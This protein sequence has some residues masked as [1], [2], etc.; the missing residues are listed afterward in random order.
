LKFT[1]DVLPVHP[2]PR[3]LESFTGYLTRLAD[4]NGI[5]HLNNLSV[6]SGF[7]F[8]EVRSPSDFPVLKAFYRLPDIA[9][10]SVEDLNGTTFY[11]LLRKFGRT[12]QSP[13]MSKHFLRESIGTHL[14]YCPMCLQ[15]HG[16]ISLLW[17]F[18]S[19]EVC[20]QHGTYLLDH[21]LHCDSVI[22][23]LANGL[24]VGVCPV[25]QHDLRTC[26]STSAPMDVVRISQRHAE[27]YRFLLKPQAW[28]EP[29]RGVLQHAGPLLRRL[30]QRQMLAI[31]QVAEA[32]A[33][34]AYVVYA[35]ESQ[36]R[37][38]RGERFIDYQRYSDLLG[39]SL[40]TLFQQAVA[41]FANEPPKRWT[42]LDIRE[43]TLLD[44]IER[45]I[46]ALQ[47]AYPTYAR[48]AKSI[49]VHESRLLLYA[50]IRDRVQA[51]QA[52]HTRQR[53]QD[54]ANLVNSARK[55]AADLAALGIPVTRKTLVQKTGIPNA[56]FGKHPELVALL[57]HYTAQR[58]AYRTAREAQLY[59]R[60]EDAI[61]FLLQQEERLT[62]LAIARLVGVAESALRRKPAIRALLH[63]ACPGHPATPPDPNLESE[64]LAQI[65]AIEAQLIAQGQPV[66]QG[67]IVQ[68][69]PIS[70]STLQRYPKAMAHLK[71][72]VTKNRQHK[73][74]QDDA[75][76]E[77]LP[78]LLNT[79]QQANRTITL[80]T[81][82]ER[83]GCSSGVLRSCVRS[84]AII[85]EALSQQT[86]A[87]KLA[88][89]QHEN[90]YLER[91]EQILQVFLTSNQKVSVKRIAA[92]LGVMPRDLRYYRRV[93]TRLEEIA[94]TN[95]RQRR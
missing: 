67:N 40:D 90:S 45:V 87:R 48:L 6:L 19:I 31:E 82:A 37:A 30:R 42:V 12:T 16:Y 85:T 63:A 80:A 77:Q 56:W 14:R 64:L 58:E 1:F 43:T 9:A 57:Q 74:T 21:C 81:V 39:E 54:D 60:V 23:F 69:L 53:L 20:P 89:Q 17:R 70:F 2:Q 78:A 59:Q 46:P 94:E 62:V 73:R 76:A 3:D 10:C 28:E 34:K 52:E 41:L 75:Y 68:R 79:L 15:E 18:L 33:V 4:E 93:R 92:Q 65:R 95:R 27:T 22:P 35:M 29:P 51:L 91:I 83:L 86:A 66:T 36:T 55:T 44:Q 32:L 7:A 71:S 72:L 88:A 11:H 25:C 49:G 13:H 5:H 38:R 8:A 84:S 26:P 61:Q 24:R 50:R 47:G